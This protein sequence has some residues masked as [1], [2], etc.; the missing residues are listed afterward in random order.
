MHTH[1]EGIIN[2]AI[3]GIMNLKISMGKNSTDA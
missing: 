3:I 2:K 1:V